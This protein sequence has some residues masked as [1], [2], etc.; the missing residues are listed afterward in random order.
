MQ[1]HKILK[2]SGIVLALIFSVD[3]IVFAQ[4]SEK[5]S[6]DNNKKTQL[7]KKVTVKTAPRPVKVVPKPPTQPKPKPVVKVVP[8][9]EPP[10]K[11]VVIQAKTPKV[12][13]VGKKG[14]FIK[15]LFK[16]PESG[17]EVEIDEKGFYVNKEGEV[18][19]SLTA[20]KHLVFVKRNGQ[21]ITDPLEL[22]VS[23]NQDIIDLSPYIKDFAEESVEKV[24]ANEVV[25]QPVEDV[26]KVEE[27]ANTAEL[28]A[29]DI[30]INSSV[31][32]NL[33]AQNIDNILLRFIQPD[34]ADSVSLNEWKYVYEQT[35]KNPVLPR[36]TKEK[37]NLINK[38]A[39][40]EISLLQQNYVQAINSFEGAVSL[41]LILKDKIGGETSVP[42]FGRGS[43]Y[44]ANK[45]Y[46]RAIESFLR[47][48]QIDIKNNVFYGVTYSRVGDAMKAS[49][50]GQEALSYY[51]SAQK[52]KYRT[53]ES[54]LKLANS[55]RQYKSYFEAA[56]IYKELGNEKPVPEIYISL[57]DC[58]VSLKQSVSAIDSY[59]R[60]TEIDPK[61]A[62][63]FLRLGNMYYEVKD[64]RFAIEAWQKA[65]DLD[66][67]G[68]VVNKK[69]IAKMIKKAKKRL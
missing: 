32:L 53:F 31:G 56:R 33:I 26:K 39:E 46:S 29:E 64:L 14:R 9:P 47:A 42:Y 65:L 4:K 43:A 52:Y 69:D 2:T 57:G 7:T 59:R 28:T 38:F 37:V 22:T 48:I 58:Y 51:L 36:Y 24:D 50:R 30:K 62:L 21:P 60:A 27:P 10:R 41:S 40:G 23:A 66:T 68:K 3:G 12:K 1:F 16:T 18:Q 49:G 44:L 67:D 63:G 55:L 6:L 13:P 17:L 45:D 15:V 20:G 54:D 61:Y 35:L 19:I 34:T 25:Q 5:T 11:K 8:K